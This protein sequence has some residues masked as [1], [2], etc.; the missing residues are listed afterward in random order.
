[1]N[2]SK[3]NEQTGISR[4]TFIRG[5][6]LTAA[7]ITVVPRHVLGGVGYVAPS[8][9][10]NIAGVGIGGIGANNLRNMNTQNIIALCDVDW[11]YAG[12]T[13]LEYPNAKKYKDYR[14]ML[15]KEK[16]IEGVMIGTPDHTHYVVTRDAMKAGK[17]VYAQKPLTRT[18]YESR[19]LTQLAEETGVC[20]QMGNQ[21]NS[22]EGIRQICE[23]IWDG[24]IG[25][26]AEVH[27]WT[28]RPIWPQGLE[29]PAGTMEIPD[30]LDWD[31]FLGPAPARPY[32]EVYH[33]WNWRAWWDYGTGA[34]GD[35]GCHILDP[36]FK[37]LK[38]KYAIAMEGSSTQL[39]TESAP[40]ASVVH[41]E[42]PARKSLPKVAM[43]AVKVSWYDGGLLPKRPSELGPGLMMGDSGGGCLFVGT[44]GKL[45]CD[46]YALK[47]R[48]LPE[49][50]DK[51]YNRPEPSLRRIENAMTGGHEM[52]WVRA[53]KEKA[54]KRVQ[55]SSNFDYA[56]PLNEMVVMGNLAIRLQDLKRKLMWDGENMKI[57][58]ISD[59]DEIKVVTS[60][61]FTVIDGD[62]RFDTKYATVKAKPA[63][64]GYIKPSY[65]EGWSL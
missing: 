4:R 19:L 25:E 43:P 28:N 11:K 47:P 36:I 40:Q 17:H 51:E 38:L 41:L 48:L 59:E 42:F 22:A 3:K 37:A 1:M 62:P 45:M 24:A 64:E 18:V 26:I 46:T 54:K 44:K 5:T 53:C 31:L 10:M 6:A 63:A 13:F 9:Q 61:K 32:H 39:N 30:T 15:D 7:G 12:K 29:R 35:M 56:G 58:N 34:L 8:D 49:E 55:P 60:D 21:G 20:T 65:R 27:A 14:E 33:P 50:L 23:W 57:T 16:D 52:D 2:K